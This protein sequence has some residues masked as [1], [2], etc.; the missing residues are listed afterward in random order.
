MTAAAYSI[1]SQTCAFQDC[2]ESAKVRGFCRSH[3]NKA[4]KRGDLIASAPAQYPPL[5]TAPDCNRPTE[6][7]GFCQ[8]HYRRMQRTGNLGRVRQETGSLVTMGGGYL[9]QTIGGETKLHHVRVVEAAIGKCL[10][11]GA[12]VH[13][14]NEI[15]SD[16]RPEN[17]VVCPNRQYH[18]ILHARQR[19]LDA[20]GH[21]NWRKCSYCKE[22]DDP[23][24]MTGLASRG[25]L[26][27]RFYHKQCAAKDVRERKAKLKL[28]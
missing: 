9:T 5:C 16:N 20:S 8:M 12:E 6:K 4:L 2:S 17:L 10:P 3:Y 11:K 25:Q 23:K 22:Y 21:A 27:N 15:T 7:R 18:M 28:K 24:N 1:T 13:H 26:L 19:A 14:V